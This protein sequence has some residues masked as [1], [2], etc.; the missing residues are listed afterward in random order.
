MIE[1]L[2]QV[3]VK[4]DCNFSCFGLLPLNFLPSLAIFRSLFAACSLPLHTFYSRQQPHLT[5]RIYYSSNS[6]PSA[7]RKTNKHTLVAEGFRGGR[8]GKE[9]N[10]FNFIEI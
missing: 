10:A 4:A 2:H 6:T 5:G 9:R 8:E 1:H 7:F 3:I